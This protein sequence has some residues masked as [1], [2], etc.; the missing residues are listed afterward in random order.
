MDVLKASALPPAA[1]RRIDESEDE[2][3]Y[4]LPRFTVHIDNAAIEAIEE[5]HATRLPANGVILDLMSSWRS[6]IPNRVKPRQIVGLGLNLAEMADNPA[7]TERI[8]HN[9]NR[10]SILPFDSDFFDGA[11]MTVSVQYLTNP[12]TT[13]REVGRVLKPGAPFIVTFSNRMFPTKAVAI[14]IGSTEAQRVELVRTYF[15]DS[16]AFIDIE[17]IQKR[18]DDTSD[19]VFAVSALRKQDGSRG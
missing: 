18:G 6:H 14:W 12:I 7:L 10:E 16:G 2:R 4:E 19:P 8:V 1:F 11:V 9:V 5:I 13:F 17:E 15:V 3:F